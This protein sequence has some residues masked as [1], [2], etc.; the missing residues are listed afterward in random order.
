VVD[1][2]IPGARV[3]RQLETAMAEHGKPVENAH[4]GSFNGRLREEFLNLTRF[5]HLW[6]ARTKAAEWLR[7]YNEER[8]HSSLGYRMHNE[9][10][11]EI[12]SALRTPQATVPPGAWPC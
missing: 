2:S 6:D 12:C 9:F 8:P 5:Q 10:D 3:I 4:A 7:H 11:A 1:T